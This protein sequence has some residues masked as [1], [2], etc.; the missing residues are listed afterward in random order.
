MRDLQPSLQLRDGV[1]QAPALV[2]RLQAA[3]AGSLLRR[4]AAAS[5]VLAAVSASGARKACLSAQ[6]SSAGLAASTAQL[7]FW[8]RPTTV[9]PAMA[10]CTPEYRIR[11]KSSATGP[12]MA[13]CKGC[14]WPAAS[15][16]LR[17]TRQID[18]RRLWLTHACADWRLRVSPTA[19]QMPVRCRWQPGLG[20]G[21]SPAPVPG[22]WPH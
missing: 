15:A 8:P 7:A 6:S 12:T 9:A 22:R 20:V 3:P 2:A 4:L 18:L 16:R 13:T 19:E 5:P 21:G 1:V 17:G 11:G 10:T 14:S